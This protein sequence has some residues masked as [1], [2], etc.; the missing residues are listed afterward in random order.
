MPICHLTLV[1]EDG[2][3]TVLDSWDSGEQ[4]LAPDSQLWVDDRCWEV[5][6][7]SVDFAAGDVPH[8]TCEPCLIRRH[9]AP[10]AAIRTAQTNEV[11][12]DSGLR[13]ESWQRELDGVKR[14]I[15]AKLN[16]GLV[17]F[18]PEYQQ[19]LNQLEAELLDSRDI[20]ELVDRL[21]HVLDVLAA[22]Y[23]ASAIM[24]ERQG[25]SRQRYL[26][27]VEAVLDGLWPPGAPQ[28]M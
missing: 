16:A 24:F 18:P 25:Q 22:G 11:R 28:P 7:F 3:T 21:K 15:R 6:N 23:L 1:D 19:A 10:D 12:L 8:L 17:G 9:L 14:L 5:V 2:E 27:T 13:Q 4:V 26:E 20:A